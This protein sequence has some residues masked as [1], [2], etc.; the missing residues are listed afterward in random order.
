MS[1]FHD[2]YLRKEEKV[3]SKLKKDVYLDPSQSMGY[4]SRMSFRAFA[5]ELEKKILKHGVTGGQWRFLRVLWENDGISQR[6]LSELVGTSEPTAVRS[7]RSLEKSK[8]VVRKRDAKDARK[9]QI[10]LT[11]KSRRLRST[12]MPYVIEVNKQAVKGISS[13]DLA[14]TKL[15]L[16]KMAVNLSH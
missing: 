10:K 6:E 12:L 7:I 5:R 11:A 4:L 2:T 16:A 9:I 8:F 15:V 13:K 3:L 1:L 14:T